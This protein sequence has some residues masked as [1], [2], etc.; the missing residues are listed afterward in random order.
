MTYRKNY[1]FLFKYMFF[2]K[3]IKFIL[4]FMKV[5]RFRVD[6]EIKIIFK[7]FILI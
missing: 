2:F 4:N 3:Q 1:E 7:K 6:F 5:S